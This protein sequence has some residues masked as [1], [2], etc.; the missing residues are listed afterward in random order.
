MTDA[1]VIEQAALAA[2]VD[3]TRPPE[4]VYQAALAVVVDETERNVFVGGSAISGL[5]LGSTP[6]SA[7][8]L[9]STQVF[10]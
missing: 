5:Y 1:V 2:V 10:G 3:T 7:A 8:Y 9:G 6:L 4:V